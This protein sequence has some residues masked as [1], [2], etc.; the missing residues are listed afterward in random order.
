MIDNFKNILSMAVLLNI[1]V[2]SYANYNYVIFGYLGYSYEYS[3]LRH[4]IANLMLFPIAVLM[5]RSFTRLTEYLVILTTLTCYLP[6]LSLYVCSEFSFSILALIYIQICVILLCKN[7]FSVNLPER[8]GFKNPAMI[9]SVLMTLLTIFFLLSRGA[10]GNIN[11]D[12]FTIYE[13]RDV[14]MKSYFTGSMAYIINWVSKGFAVYLLALGICRR[15]MS[16]MLAAVGTLFFL[17]ISLGQ[18]TPIAMVFFVIFAFF[19]TT[20]KIQVWQ[21]SLILSLGVLGSHLVY[22]LLGIPVAYSIFVKRIFF[23]PAHAMV[24][25]YE[26]FSSNGFTY[27]SDSILRHVVDYPFK[28]DPQELIALRISGNIDLNPNVGIL[29]T[30]YQHAGIVGVLMFGFIGGV[31]VAMCES[32]GKRFPPQFV[33]AVAG[34]YLYIML[35][36]SDLFRSFLT[37]GGAVVLLLLFLT[38]T[39]DLVGRGRSADHALAR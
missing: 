32:L 29:G 9:L 17:S 1:L 10:L 13:T 2:F 34:P 20:R 8:T 7:I 18:K 35:T 6:L 30:G 33:I 19:V 14:A 3:L 26:F 24:N 16:L 21:F 27:L 39:R 28:Y 31:L 23:A 38:N 11:F 22:D 37:H 36:S 12:I 5:P 15:S 25:Y 4:L